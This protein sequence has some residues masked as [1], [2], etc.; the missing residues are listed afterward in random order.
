[1]ASK[2][3]ARRI[4]GQ[5]A[6]AST[7]RKKIQFLRFAVTA[8]DFLRRLNDVTFVL[9]MQKAYAVLIMSFST[10]AASQEASSLT[11]M[12]CNRNHSLDSLD[13]CFVG[14]RNDNDSAYWKLH[15]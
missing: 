13:E 9:K 15:W 12:R 3:V 11:L 7:L 8:D 2:L 4:N 5:S 14:L 6:I 10:L 1:M